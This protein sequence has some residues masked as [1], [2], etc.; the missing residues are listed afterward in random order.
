MKPPETF[1]AADQLLDRILSSPARLGRHRLVCI[2]GPAGAGKTT[3]AVELAL[4]LANLVPPSATATVVHLDDLYSGWAQDIS[5]VGPLLSRQIVT[6]VLEGRSAGYRRFDWHRDTHA[7]WVSVSPSDVLIL[8]GVGAGH[9][10]LA[11]AR[12]MLIWVSAE[13]AICLERG[14]ARDGEPLRPHWL[15]WQIREAAY[16]TEFGVAEQADIWWATE[17]ASQPNRST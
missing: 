12:S 7:D 5:E 14:L 11:P 3:L 4:A 6:P 10:V 1:A 17:A 15:D 2:D 13:P 9:P 16:F 8:E